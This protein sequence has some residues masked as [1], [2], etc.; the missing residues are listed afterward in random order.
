M[1]S[2]DF[3]GSQLRSG[4]DGRKKINSSISVTIKFHLIFK[5]VMRIFANKNNENLN[6][7][8]YLEKSQKTN[9][10]LMFSM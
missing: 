4:R 2:F 5:A 8:V 6:L 3:S 1:T 7:E 9:K 10:K